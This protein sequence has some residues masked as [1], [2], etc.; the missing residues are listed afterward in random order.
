MLMDVFLLG[1]KVLQRRGHE[2]RTH[3][4]QRQV[5]ELALGSLVDHGARQTFVR[6]RASAHQIFHRG[7][8]W[9]LNWDSVDFSQI[10][11]RSTSWRYGRARFDVPF[12][13]AH[14]RLEPLLL[15]VPCRNAQLDEVLS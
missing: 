11:W 6:R 2:P 3:S 5:H 12:R 4:L 7:P 9:R 15:Q 10:C 8:R 1:G 13:R 14:T